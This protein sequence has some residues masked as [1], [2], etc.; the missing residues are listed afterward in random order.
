MACF[1]RINHDNNHHLNSLWLQAIG[2]RASP[3]LARLPAI[4]TGSLCILAAAL[5]TGRRS[6]TAGI[7]AAILFALSPDLVV[8][9]SEARGY[10]PMLL[11]ALVMLYC[12]SEEL[13]GCSR[14]GGRWFLACVA[15]LGMFSHL[16]MTAP[17]GIAA[18]VVLSRAARLGRPE[19]G[20]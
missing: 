3:L 13:D 14:K 19:C 7:V 1:F 20:S 17:V 15:I 8:F 12:V 16:T 5:L 4:M 10:A 2:L 11:A 18:G 9:G 6:A